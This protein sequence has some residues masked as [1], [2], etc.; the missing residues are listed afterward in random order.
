MYSWFKHISPF[1]GIS[2][3]FS[4]NGEMLRKTNFECCVEMHFS[5]FGAALRDFSVRV[6]VAALFRCYEKMGL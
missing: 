4:E 5:G 1:L 2:V 6:K 3:T